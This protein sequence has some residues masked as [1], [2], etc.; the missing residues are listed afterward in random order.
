MAN[1]F[2]PL[3]LPANLHDLPQG[4]AQRIK[5]FGVKGDITTQ[6]HLDILFDLL[7]WNRC[8]MIM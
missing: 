8:I 7:T 2:V 3:V 5:Q 1:I 6:Q 4:Y